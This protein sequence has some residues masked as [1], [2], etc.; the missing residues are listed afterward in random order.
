[1]LEL[2]LPQRNPN[3]REVSCPEDWRERQ[4]YAW[5][6]FTARGPAPQNSFSIPHGC[7]SC[8]TTPVL[9]LEAALSV[10]VLAPG[11]VKAQEPGTWFPEP[12]LIM[13]LA[14]SGRVAEAEP[15]GGYGLKVRLERPTLALAATLRCCRADAQVGSYLDTLL[16]LGGSR[17][18]VGIDLQWTE[19][20]LLAG[21]S[22]ALAF[23]L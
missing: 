21:Q 6:N 10:G 15:F 18:V 2:R 1:M 11:L 20:L 9:I 22:L 12:H 19:R 14:T 8:A 16:M 17:L 13:G 5:S 3:I 23:R 7:Q 4:D